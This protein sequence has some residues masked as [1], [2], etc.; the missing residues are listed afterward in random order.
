MH[1]LATTSGVIDGGATA[2]DLKQSPG[3]IVV[4]SAADSE[5]A[6]LAMA[7]DQFEP[8]LRLANLLQLQHN[9]S[10]D[11]YTEQTLARAKLIIVRLLGGK[12][13]WPYGVASLLE[14]TGVKLALLPGGSDQD[15]E[16][17]ALS[18]VSGEDWDALRGYFASGGPEN[19][20]SALA[21]AAWKLGEGEK[22]TAFKLF[23]TCSH[24]NPSFPGT[25]ES[26]LSTS[27]I[28]ESLVSRVRGNDGLGGS[29]T[30]IFY[31]SVVEGGQTAPLNALIEQLEHHG[32]TTHAIYVSS[33]KDK[34]CQIFLREHFAKNPADVIINATSFAVGNLEHDILAQ[35]GCPVLQVTLGGN[36]E[37]QWR[38]STAG[39]ASKDLA[40]SV[41][42]PELDGRIYAGVISFKADHLWLLPTGGDFGLQF[43]RQGLEQFFVVLN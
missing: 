16:L 7:S 18:S 25:R 13:Y 15:E 2:V 10:V 34:T 22:P 19:I 30:I 42:L 20:R 28:V 26:R 36:T 37:E 9:Y 8:S 27:E 24:Y 31:R 41:V 43:F 39:L 12:A 5:L 1:L 33:L 17:K 38:S 21:Y 23:A 4:L 6:A 3:D 35:Q 40:M 11:L 14:L 29:A 32:L